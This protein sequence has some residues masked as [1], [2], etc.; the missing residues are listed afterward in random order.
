MPPTHQPPPT[1][2]ETLRA[3]VAEYRDRRR[4]SQQQLADRLAH[5]GMTVNRTA[6]TKIESGARQVTVDEH[7]ALAAALGV[8]PVALV[9][10]VS[11]KQ[12]RIAPELTTSS[13]LA[14]LWMTGHQPIGGTQKNEHQSDKNIRFYEEA[15]P[16]AHAA[17]ERLL[18]GVRRLAAK[19]ARLQFCGASPE[20]AT[21]DKL[22]YAVHELEGIKADVAELLN[23]ARRDL[24]EAK[25]S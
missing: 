17:T 15:S 22:T 23:R 13:G 16:D 3:N 10:P 20:V 6:V 25:A 11:E 14:H 9:V 2:S 24:D 7:T 18:P 21:V 12:M 1:P 8:A 19:A 4:W 5:Y